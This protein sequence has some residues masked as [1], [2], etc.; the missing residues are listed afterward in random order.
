MIDFDTLLFGPA[1]RVFADPAVLTI[2][3]AS[4]TVD[5]IDG[6]RGIAVD[7]S[8]MVG[9]ET[10]RPV[11]DVRRRQLVQNGIAVD[12]LID[13]VVMLAGQTWRIKSPLELSRDELRLILMAEDAAVNSAVVYRV[14]QSGGRR[15]TESGQLRVME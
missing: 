12:D 2:G 9:V 11:V 10:V 7:D 6:T 8:A 1:Y 4:Y 5:V 14:T 3:A 15:I 13:A